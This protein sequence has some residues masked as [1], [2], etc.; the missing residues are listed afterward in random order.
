[1][2]AKP[3]CEGVSAS[4]FLCS[5][6]QWRVVD[7][8]SSILKDMPTL[9]LIFLATFGHVVGFYINREPATCTSLCYQSE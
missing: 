8:V 1:M 7:R 6:T 4:M 3:H 5:P 2:R 9:F